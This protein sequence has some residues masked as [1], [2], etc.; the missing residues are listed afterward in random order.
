MSL[1]TT[2]H[3]ILI[4]ECFDIVEREKRWKLWDHCTVCHAWHRSTNICLTAC[5][6]INNSA[7][8]ST[9]SLGMST[10]VAL[11]DFIHFH[12]LRCRWNQEASL[13]LTTVKYSKVWQGRYLP[14]KQVVCQ[15]G[16][17]FFGRKKIGSQ[18][19]WW[20]GSRWV[21]T[22]SWAVLSLRQR[23]RLK[24][25]SFESGEREMGERREPCSTLSL[26]AS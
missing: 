1:L 22:N 7:F 23:R 8:S 5:N 4:K 14:G 15:K 25:A 18:P 10:A 12:C 19:V 13:V 3:L 6:A 16:D 24:E 2:F 26:P 20:W 11:Q 21:G 9:F 17:A